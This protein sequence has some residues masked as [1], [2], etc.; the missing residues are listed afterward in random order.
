MSGMPCVI[1]ISGRGTNL[2]AILRAVAEEGLPLDIRAVISNRPEAAGLEQARR[3]GLPSYVLDHTLFADRETFDRELQELIDRHV[4]Q[5]VI[6]AGFMRILSEKFVSHYRGRLINIHPSLL[7]AFPGL[8][9]HRR[10]LAAG[11]GEHGATVHFVTE[12]VDGGPVIVQACVSVLAEDTADTLAARVLAEEH[13]IYP[14]V[15]RWFAEGRLR[16]ERHS[17]RDC[18]VLDGEILEA[19]EHLLPGEVKQ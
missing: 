15:L 2:Q 4:P 8:N 9:T 6:L 3:A 5:L 17:G 14:Q 10:A 19:S 11:V 1:L 16:L 13:R 12:A 18:A 7:P